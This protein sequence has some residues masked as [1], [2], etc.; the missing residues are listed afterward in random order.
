MNED[1]DAIEGNLTFEKTVL[2]S[3]SKKA[4]CQRIPT[5]S[6]ACKRIQFNKSN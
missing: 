5:R 4:S 2:L 1:D 3:K 6:S